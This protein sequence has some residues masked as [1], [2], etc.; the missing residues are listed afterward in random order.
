[1]Q[2]KEPVMKRAILAVSLACAPLCAWSADKDGKHSV[3]GQIPCGKFVEERAA[4]GAQATATLAWVAGYISAY[5]LWAPDTYNILGNSHLPDAMRWLEAYCKA[6]P[7]R[8][9]PTAMSALVAELHPRR[10]RSA[11]E[12]GR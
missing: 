12:A 9:L 11:A 2:E 4:G 10:H 6:N 3:Q 1:M 8:D 5:N 7:Q